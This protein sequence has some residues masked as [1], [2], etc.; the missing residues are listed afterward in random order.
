[1]NRAVITSLARIWQQQQASMQS[2]L[3]TIFIWRDNENEPASTCYLCE[4]SH[5]SHDTLF[6]LD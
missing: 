1:M 3:D 4:F 2:E 6:S 5:F